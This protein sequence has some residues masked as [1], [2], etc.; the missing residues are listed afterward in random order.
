MVLHAVSNFQKCSEADN[1]KVFG[2]N[3]TD[4]LWQ[5]IFKLQLWIRRQWGS[6]QATIVSPPLSTERIAVI[7]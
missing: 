5:K 3:K 1:P 2:I 6:L 4:D 7:A